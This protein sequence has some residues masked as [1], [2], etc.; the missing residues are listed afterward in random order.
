M[1][2]STCIRKLAIILVSM[3]LS[4]L[5]FVPAVTLGGRTKMQFFGISKYPMFLNP[6]SM[7]FP[8]S[9]HLNYV[10]LNVIYSSITSSIIL[11]SSDSVGTYSSE[12]LLKFVGDVPNNTFPMLSCSMYVALL[13]TLIGDTLASQTLIFVVVV[14]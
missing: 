13:F 12:D 10:R 6:L 7:S 8:Q 1:T 3:T 9:R 11:V 14:P 4:L 5:L 2:R